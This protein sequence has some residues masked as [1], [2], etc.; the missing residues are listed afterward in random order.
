[1]KRLSAWCPFNKTQV[2]V[3][4]HDAQCAISN[5]A[6]ICARTLRGKMT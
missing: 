1:M 4:S 2:P 5:A 3:I 6:E